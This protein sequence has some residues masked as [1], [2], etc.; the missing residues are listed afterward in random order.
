MDAGAT[1]TDNYDPNVTITIDDSQVNTNQVGTYYVTITATDMYGNTSEETR[2]VV[3][4]DT[5]APSVTVEY[6][7]QELTNQDV[8]VTIV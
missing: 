4:V 6:T 8:T 1:A 2:P 3:V 7:T 5:V